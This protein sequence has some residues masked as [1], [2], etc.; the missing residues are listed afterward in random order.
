MEATGMSAFKSHVNRIR[1]AI[2]A[3]KTMVVRLYDRPEV[4]TSP[5]TAAGRSNNPLCDRWR[6]LLRNIEL[7]HAHLEDA[8]MRLGK[9]LQAFE[10]KDIYDSPEL[11]MKRAEEI[12]G[13]VPADIPPTTQER[14]Q[15]KGED[16]EGV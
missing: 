13:G 1:D 2:E 14:V 9:V 15:Y 16:K 5:T 12:A 10:G 4:T 7:A 6:V 3:D 11:L 8:R